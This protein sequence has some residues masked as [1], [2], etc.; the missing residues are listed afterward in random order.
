MGSPVVLEH[1]HLGRNAT[2]WRH[3]ARYQA[4]APLYRGDVFDLGCG[5]GHGCSVIASSPFVRSVTLFDQH[6]MGLPHYE[7]VEISGVW[8]RLPGTLRKMG[9]NTADTVAC[10]EFIEHVGLEDQG[11]LCNEAH[12]VLRPGGHFL[13]STPAASQTGPSESNPWHLRELERADCA[14]ML[15]DTGFT[16]DASY[17]ADMGALT[18]GAEVRVAFLVGRK[19]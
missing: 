2:D 10:V 5:T 16:V 6:A 19:G 4:F 13:V 11:A 15:M 12:R 18:D 1:H 3:R 8:G 7:G 9:A 17:E 14:R